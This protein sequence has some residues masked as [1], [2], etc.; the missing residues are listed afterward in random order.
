ML[1]ADPLRPSFELGRA[2]ARRG[3]LGWLVLG[4]LIVSGAVS[5]SVAAV[6][7][8]VP[9]VS[10]PMI[11]APVPDGPWIFAWGANA[12]PPS[13]EQQEQVSALR[14]VA[15]GAAALVWVLCLLT[16]AGLWRQRLMLR[17]HEYFVHWALGAR[18]LQTAARL[19]G[20]ARVWV[21]AAMGIA[22][23]GT[24]SVASFIDRSFP[25]V[26]PIA[27]DAA[28]T[29][30]LLSALSVVLIRWECAAGARSQEAGRSRM[31]E[32]VGSPPM[33]GAIGIAA[34]TG[35][36]LLAVHAPQGPTTSPAAGSV[37][38]VSLAHVSTDRRGDVISEWTA[39][40]RAGGREIG[41]ASAGATR[42][43]G[44]RDFATVECGR[45][46]EGLM[47]MPLKIVSP[48]V[49]AV[50]PDTFAHLGMIVTSGRDFDE[51]LDRGSPSTAIVSRALAARHFEDGNPLGRRLRVA[52]SGWL[53]IVGV[54]D[55]S[56]DYAVYL[57]L[58]QARPTDIEVLVSGS[59]SALRPALDAAPAGAV[60]G[61]AQS[62]AE[63]F[64]VHRWFRR[65][66]SGMGVAALVLLGAGLWVSAANEAAATGPEIAVRRAVGATRRSFWT[67]Y[68]AFAGR[69]LVFALLVGGWLSLFLGAALESASA[70]IPRFDWRIWCGVA[71]W[72]SAMYLIGSLRPMLRGASAPLVGGLEGSA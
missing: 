69:R 5:F 11:E 61:N 31:W 68:V 62:K 22:A 66:L 55:G 33:L 41:F 2:E 40:A 49:Y 15:G 42:G 20:E 26:A 8:R 45:C 32:L 51:V 39:L 53:T 4:A 30:I 24:V 59:A 63:V 58:A 28:A 7:L 47:P 46:F 54:V 3:L 50:A 35:V 21:G 70:S 12:V 56:D 71:A 18:K 64:S 48:E 17:R 9:L 67:F 44:R 14:T 52:E 19:I 72:V 1:S 6:M 27:P 36:G 43:T 34:L 16:I 60:L 10:G 38:A 13:V 37:A 29:A 25:G 57:P 65:W 23:V